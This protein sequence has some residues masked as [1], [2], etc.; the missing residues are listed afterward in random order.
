MCAAV[1]QHRFQQR[2]HGAA[3]LTRLIQHAQTQGI[4]H[5]GQ[6]G[7]HGGGIGQ[8]QAPQGLHRIPPH[9]VV[10]VPRVR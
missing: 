1:T 2:Q 8:P 9:R 5:G 4:Q 6:V 7:V 10:V 3:D